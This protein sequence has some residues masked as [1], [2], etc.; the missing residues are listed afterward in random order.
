M[1]KTSNRPL[2]IAAICVFSALIA[3]IVFQIIQNN[4][5][6]EKTPGEVSTELGL[7][8][9]EKWP[10]IDQLPIKNSLYTIGYTIKNNDLKIY[11]D[12][13]DTYLE[14]ALKKL[15]SLTYKPLSS[16]NIEIR[17]PENPFKG[18]FMEKF[19]KDPL[20]FFQNGYKDAAI[21]YEITS[22]KSDN[23][24]YLIYLTTGSE[25]AY[26]LVHYTA[27]LEKS[28]DSWKLVTEPTPTLLLDQ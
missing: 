20:E 17:T 23:D 9:R 24:S 11:I 7:S 18:C 19:A 15:G 22:A 27:V 5:N 14:V 16:Y 1:E 26:D 3:L 12:T 21:S 25:E 6:L 4:Q 28:G 10:I 13:T 2:I 8:E